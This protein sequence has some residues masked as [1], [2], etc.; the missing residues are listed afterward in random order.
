MFDRISNR[1]LTEIRTVVGLIVGIVVTTWFVANLLTY[2]WAAEGIADATVRGAAAA[3][4]VDL[5]VLVTFLSGLVVGWVVL[6]VADRSKRIQA[7]AFA[8]V[9]VLFFVFTLTFGFFRDTDWVGDGAS[10]LA[11]AVLAVAL[12]ASTLVVSGERE[13]PVATAGIHTV[14]LVSVGTGI[15]DA[16]VLGGFLGAATSLTELATTVAT[17]LFSLAFVVLTATLVQSRDQRRVTIVSPNDGTGTAVTVGLTKYLQRGFESE[18]VAGAQ[19]VANAPGPMQTGDKPDPLGEPVTVTYKS[20]QPI[21]RWIKV[22]AQPVDVSWLGAEERAAFASETSRPVELVRDVA[23]RLVLPY[24]ELVALVRSRRSTDRLAASIDE[25]D[26][27]ICVASAED[28]L[29]YDV[30]RETA[31]MTDFEPPEFLEDMKELV[32]SLDPDTRVVF[33]VYE[34][35]TVSEVYRNDTGRK[36]SFDDDLRDAVAEY[37]L[38]FPVDSVVVVDTDEES[39]ELLNGVEPLR[40]QLDFGYR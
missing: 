33:A 16:Y 38:D 20:P 17:L 36:P 31:G 30:D 37:M 1:R 5:S 13:F 28:F 19:T 25:A 7:P 9:A 12:G 27:V 3:L 39:N 14:V 40:Y 22:T 35:D 10:L 24:L 2:A 18:L 6:L 26:I 11:G 34:G 15:V 23:K 4:S 32:F 21:S 8:L 29:P